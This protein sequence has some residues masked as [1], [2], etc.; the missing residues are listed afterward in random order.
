MPKEFE[1]EL[2]CIDNAFIIL[3]LLH[4]PILVYFPLISNKTVSIR[5]NKQHLVH[6]IISCVTLY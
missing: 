4:R 2:G 5:S 6:I 3:L 1:K